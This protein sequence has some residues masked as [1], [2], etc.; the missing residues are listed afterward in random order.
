MAET[1]ELKPD[2]GFVERVANSG[3]ADVKKC[4]QCATCSVMCELSPD[5]RPFPRKE[6]IWTQWGLK[7]R[8]FADPDVWLC[9]QCGDCTT[10]C[11]RGAKP[12]DVLAAVRREAVE[13]YSIPGFLARAVNNPKM[14]PILLIVP[15]LLLGAGL[16]VQDTF[17]G[18]PVQQGAHWEYEHFFGH[19][20]LIV[21]FTFFWNAAILLGLVG[22]WRFWKAM[23][24]AD[25][26]AGRKPAA[27]AGLVGS[28][29]KACKDIATHGRFSKCT[30]Q[31]SR[32]T[33]HLMAVYGFVIL[34]VVTLW[35]I[36]ILYLTGKQGGLLEYPFGPV[37]PAKIAGY[38]GA[39]GLIVGCAV[40]IY[41]RMNRKETEGRSTS[42]D[43]TFV[44]ILLGVAV[45]GVLTML[46]RFAQVKAAGYPLY[47]IHLVLVF[48]LLVY[49]PY[50][51][52]AHVF[53]RTAAMAYAYH[54]GRDLPPAPEP[55][56]KAEAEQ[57][58]ERKP[59]EEEKKESPENPGEKKEEEKEKVSA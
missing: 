22:V 31:P 49:M 54:A 24:A 55:Q 21:F 4:F 50:S 48:H 44:W 59:A 56:K 47:F 30:A 16:Y 7:D 52:F 25:A 10:H 23:K 35:A 18:P 14:L 11:P 29:I 43:W 37:N 53:Y 26:Q 28:L 39:L 58:E 13:H 32:K 34:L 45:T 51:K 19:P 20:L 36:V 41:N 40:L 17:G 33:P 15:A 1:V 3:G 57:K 2:L 27:G 9:H 38:I 12:G 5:D 46:L 42:F 6:M 8:L